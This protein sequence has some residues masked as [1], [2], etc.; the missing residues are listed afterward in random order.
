MSRYNL[1]TALIGIIGVMFSI[2]VFFSGAFVEVK[3][4]LIIFG[5]AVFAHS[6]RIL[7]RA[8][9]GNNSFV[10]NSTA[11]DFNPPIITKIT[12]LNSRGM[13]VSTWEL[14]GRVSAVIG[15][16]VGENH[17]DIDLSGDPYASMVEVEHAVLNYA[18]GDWYVEDLG[19]QN[20]VSIKK[21][22][23]TKVFKIGSLEPCKLD[24]GDIIF[25]GMCQL[26]LN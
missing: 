21:A 11:P 12:L 7:Y 18:D 20:G 17:V 22:S 16:D 13:S 2:A 6:A 25:V 1:Y 8:Q 9:S 4:L 23:S 19:S 14:Y 26:K 3:A 10:D 5:A 24:F 15:K